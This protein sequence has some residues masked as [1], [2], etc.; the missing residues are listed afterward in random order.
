MNWHIKHIFNF[1]P[2]KP[3]EHGYVNF[4]F[5]GRSGAQYFLH[6]NEHWLGCLTA[7]DE[8]L[9]TAG[10]VDKG[11]SRAHI[12]FDIQHP[13]YITELPDDSLLVASNGTNQIFRL[14]PAERA[15]E[16]FA[17]TGRLGFRDLGNCV[18]HGAGGADSPG[19]SVWAHEIEGCRVWQLDLTGRPL[20]VLGR[21]EPGFQR[22]T[23]PFAAA[24][25]HWIYD[26]RLGPDGDLYVLDSRNYCVRRIEVGRGMVSLVAGTGEPGPAL[27]HVPASAA[28]FGSDPNARF[29]GPFAL[30]LD[31]AGNVFVGDTYNHVVRMVERATGIISTIA[32]KVA[33]EPGVR[34]DP[35]ETDP[36]KLNLPLICSM[37]YHAGCLFVPDWSND[38]IVL[39]KQ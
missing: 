31:E 18:Y 16:L 2:D 1:P 22:E 23:V 12:P 30:S 24:R 5:H 9:W 19:G 3:W 8:W 28:T 38:L 34:N 36:L 20:A 35:A 7:D 6:Y 17:D 14:R 21:G 33:A 15:V 39:E 25:F 13:H 10:A 11:L 26:L 29:D 4:G 37:D 32:G 27:D